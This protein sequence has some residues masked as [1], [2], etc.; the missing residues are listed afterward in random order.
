MYLNQCIVIFLQV[1]YCLLKSPKWFELIWFNVAITTTGRLG[2]RWL[3]TVSW[4]VGKMQIFA[5][6]NRS[7]GRGNIYCNIYW[8]ST[9]MFE[10]FFII[11]Y[12]FFFNFNHPIYYNWNTIGFCYMQHILK[13]CVIDHVIVYH[14]SCIQMVWGSIFYRSWK[15][16]CN[17][18][19]RTREI[20]E[21]AIMATS[22]VF[23]MKMQHSG[24]IWL[25]IM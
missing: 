19:N 25:Y 7:L 1:D 15:Y 3:P 4:K 8:H 22:F 18:S 24:V 5:F 6:S 2:L 9:S 20:K 17:V 14:N 10:V 21:I 16:Y 11:L 23:C 12:S 13:D